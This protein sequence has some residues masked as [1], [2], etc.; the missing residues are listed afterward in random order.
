MK[1]STAKQGK[2]LLTYLLTGGAGLTLGLLSFGG[3][4]AIYPS[5]TLGLASFALATLYEGEIY[6]SNIYDALKKLSSKHYYRQQKANEVL[7]ELMDKL[8]LKAKQTPQF[9][10]DYQLALAKLA[11]L[12]K[13]AN[14]NPTQRKQLK[15]A[16][17]ELKQLQAF[18]SQAVFGQLTNQQPYARQL[19]VFLETHQDGALQ[20]EAIAHESSKKPLL[21][22]GLIFSLILAPLFGFG[23]IYLIYDTL[24]TLTF[25]SLSFPTVVALASLCGAAYGL[26]IYNTI[27]D[28]I[29]HNTLSEWAKELKHTI[30]TAPLPQA[31]AMVVTTTLIVT[32]SVALT[33][34][35][36]GTWWTIAKHTK[37]LPPAMKKIPT[38]ITGVIV[39]FFSGIAALLFT[40]ENTKDSIDSAMKMF[41]PAPKPLANR[42]AQSTNEAP[43]PNHWYQWLNPFNWAIFLIETPLTIIGFVLHICSIGVTT[44]RIP[45]VH[46]IVSALMSTLSEAF[47]DFHYFIGNEVNEQ[48]NAKDDIPSQIIRALLSPLYL[49]SVCWHVG[50]SHLINEPVSWQQ[51]WNMRFHGRHQQPDSANDAQATA[52]KAKHESEPSLAWQQQKMLMTLG[53]ESQRLADANDEQARAKKAVI[54]EVRQKV[55]S[56]NVQGKS[57]QQSLAQALT[58]PEGSIQAL[59]THRSY[60][61]DGSRPQSLEVYDDL[62]E[63]L[64][65]TTTVI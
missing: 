35:T 58:L 13:I 62:Q 1:S 3:F 44:D 28:M 59:A 33:I 40:L 48:T 45:G 31:I 57:P 29:W 14:P 38:F 55:A 50:G 47:E 8:N 53:Q 18:F 32:L 34:F 51:A 27:T 46:P 19:A 49:L 16:K 7:L 22:A 23:S 64:S 4:Y 12:N 9:F 39:P 63:A 17:A 37:N 5:I 6:S 26:L 36:A 25:I 60:L 65:V 42:Q 54:D 15:Q 21:K 43:K 24:A 41:K 10:K 30:K 61:H 11:A 52:Q 20:R 2:K 56:V